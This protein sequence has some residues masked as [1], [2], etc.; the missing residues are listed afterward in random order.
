MS[1]LSSHAAD[2]RSVA[3]IRENLRLVA[4]IGRQFANRGVDTPD[5][6]QEGNIG[7]IKASRRFD[8]GRGV[9]FSTYA[10][11][12]IRQGMGRAVAEQG[13]AVRLPHHVRGAL[14][15]VAQTTHDLV[16]KLGRAPGTAE[17][18]ARL[19]STPD[20]IEQLLDL[21]SLPVSLDAP[22]S[23]RGDD[24]PLIDRL[25]DAE[26]ARSV[27]EA[28]EARLL[29]AA[30]REALATLRPREREVL[31][32]RFGIDGDPCNLHEVAARVG[33]HVHRVRQIE[34]RALK[35]LKHDP[36]LNSLRG[37]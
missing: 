25:A 32:L 29:G 10:A 36:R 34:K 24:L 14:R 12:W 35:K 16:G 31:S 30:I 33:L 23:Q 17:I 8:E 21:R 7:L 3:L 26:S 27:E 20:R 9:R 19:S 4:L 22:S 13:R 15:E 11:W 5:L 6:I 1:S 18:A 2:D 37:T 28:F